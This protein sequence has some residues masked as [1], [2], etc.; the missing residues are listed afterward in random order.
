MKPTKVAA[1]RLLDGMPHRQR[2]PPVYNSYSRVN[3]E[4][5]HDRRMDNH[6]MLLWPLHL[7]SFCLWD[8]L[9]EERWYGATQIVILSASSKTSIGLAFALAQDASAPRSVALTST[10]HRPFVDS[11]GLYE[12]VL[13]YDD[14]AALDSTRPTVLVDMSGDSQVLD[15]LR[16]HLGD[17]LQRCIR[18]GVTHWD[19][20]DGAAGPGAERTQMFFAPSHIQRRMQ[21]W[22]PEVFAERSSAFVQRSMVH[23]H[24]W[25]QFTT[26]PG[27]QG[28]ADIYPELVQGRVPPDQGLIVELV[29]DTDDSASGAA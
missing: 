12:Q 28:L 19:Q 10:R 23:S 14:L 16:N 27:L 20:F 7:T 21:E 22:G 24:Q 17:Q 6:R 18:V 13:G 11:L 29:G 25:L 2:L 3:A 5:D 26:V 4:P 1:Q 8:L 9:Q 15:Q